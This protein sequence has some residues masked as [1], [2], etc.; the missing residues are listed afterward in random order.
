MPSFLALSVVWGSSF[1]L[2]KVAL[3]EGVAPVWVAFGR[4]FFGV[5]ALGAICLVRR[6][7]LPGSRATWSHA[8]AV[9]ALLNALPFSFLAFG[10]THVSS[11]LAGVF[12][13]VT[14][15]STLLFS[16][17]LV[18]QEQLT[19]RRLSGLSV[20]F[21]G[22]LV[23]LGVWQGLGGAS[24]VGS[25]ACIASTVCLGAGF[26]YTR[27]FFSGRDGSAVALSTVQLICATVELALLAPLLNGAPKVPGAKG[28]AALAVLGAL[29]TGIAY[30][31]NLRVIRVAGPT[32]ASTVTY[33]IPLWS[34]LFGTLLLSEPLSWNT[35]VGA[36][37]VVVGVVL[38]RAP[39]GRTPHRPVPTGA[40][41]EPTS[42]Q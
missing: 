41:P 23:V 9:A 8:L 11:V 6:D 40:E 33:V 31:L 29:G 19:A 1:A 35:L 5:L 16:L 13:A 21:C 3:D 27:R 17:A 7:A 34:T 38:T 24:L 25:L 12:N 32:I 10:E 14:P 28:L 4:C 18:P 42:R 15:L 20:G 30:I 36:C 39:G 26:A 22:V 37:L 2:I